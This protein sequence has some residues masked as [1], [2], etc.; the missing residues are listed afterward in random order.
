MQDSA[1]TFDCREFEFTVDIREGATA[2]NSL[3]ILFFIAFCADRRR[4]MSRTLQIRFA[5]YSSAARPFRAILVVADRWGVDDANAL[6]IHLP[7]ARV[8]EETSAI[9]QEHGNDMDFHFVN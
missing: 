6:V 1:E 5:I 4:A 2:N 3:A 8:V 9:T 7:S